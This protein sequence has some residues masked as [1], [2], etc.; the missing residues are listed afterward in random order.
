MEF[1]NQAGV[2]PGVVAAVAWSC[3]MSRFV[4]GALALIA[5]RLDHVGTGGRPLRIRAPYTV[6][7]PLNVL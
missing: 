2:S 1:R 4:L 6:N 7:Q 5:R 3:V